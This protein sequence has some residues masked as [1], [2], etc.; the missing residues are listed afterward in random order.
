MTKEET[1]SRIKLLF[2]DDDPI[3]V[4]SLTLNLNKMGWS[5]KYVIDIDTLF[6]ELSLNHYDILILDLVAPIPVIEE[7]KYVNFEESDIDEMGDDGTLTGV[8]LAK[9][10]WAIDEYKEIPV[11]F[12]S[13]RC[14]PIPGDNEL[15]N[16]K[17]SFIRKPEFAIG[18]DKKL[19]EMLNI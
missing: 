13:A 12:H 7:C 8:V 14:S 10:I 6:Y 3:T 4:K 16:G 17:C 2:F 18:I 15:Q 19:R 11:L 5:V 1:K 9:K